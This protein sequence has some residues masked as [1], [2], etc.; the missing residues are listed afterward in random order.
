VLPVLVVAAVL[1]AAF[2]GAVLSALVGAQ[3]LQRSECAR[4]VRRI[5]V[6]RRVQEAPGVVLSALFLGRRRRWPLGG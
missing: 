1:Q 3:A 6:A 2:L 5:R 4:A